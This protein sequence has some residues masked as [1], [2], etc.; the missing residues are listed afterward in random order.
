ML[1]Y[2]L[3]CK[4]NTENIDPRVLK[5]KNNKAMLPSKCVV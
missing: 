4:N 1:P 2:C 5:T 3:K